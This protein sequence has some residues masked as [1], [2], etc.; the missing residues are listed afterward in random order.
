MV[1]DILLILNKL[2]KLNR[3]V[4]IY[5]SSNF[6]KP[7]SLAIN[8]ENG[9]FSDD[10]ASGFLLGSY[11]GRLNFTFWKKGEKSSENRDNKLSLNIN[12]AILL[13]NF[14]K[15]IITR[16]AEEYT[17]GGMQ[18]YSDITN[19]QFN[20]EGYVNGQLT[21]FGNVRFD[22]VDI[23]GI[24]RIKMTSTRGNTVNTVV[25]CDNFMKSAIPSE[26]KVKT[27]YD[28]FDTSFIRFCTDVNNW[29]NFTWMQGGFNK[30]F[31]TV[32]GKKGGSS[33]NGGGS[34]ESTSARYSSNDSGEVFEQDTDF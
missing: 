11:A 13:N 4:V 5:M 33:Y 1:R 16:R 24:K 30:I 19:L 14:L 26:S 9:Y 8:L 25:F 23:D 34:G 7:L 29:V 31:N 22:T 32:A 21:N 15:F 27:Q 17:K 20:I 2:N 18:S 10:G 28:L 6:V 12:Q 3:K